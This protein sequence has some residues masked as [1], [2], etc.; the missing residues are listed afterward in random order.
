[1]QVQRSIHQQGNKKQERERELYL[2]PLFGLD[3]TR[4]AKGTDA[5]EESAKLAALCQFVK[6]KRRKR[7]PNCRVT[8]R[9]MYPY[10]VMGQTYRWKK[11][12]KKRF[13]G[14]K[15]QIMEN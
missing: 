7:E 10:S 14:C 3:S 4:R 11:K 12:R 6:E 13:C 1:M 9:C 15:L 5:G 2:I 8:R